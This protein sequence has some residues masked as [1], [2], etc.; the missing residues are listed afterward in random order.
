M[1]YLK[2]A[3]VYFVVEKDCI[4]GEL[5]DDKN[6]ANN[7]SLEISGYDLNNKYLVALLTNNQHLIQEWITKTINKLTGEAENL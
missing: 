3:D 2:N 6:T 7:P 1:S 5:D 4:Y